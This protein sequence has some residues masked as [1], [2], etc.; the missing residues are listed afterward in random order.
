MLFPWVAVAPVALI[1][2]PMLRLREHYGHADDHP[3]RI[4]EGTN[5]LV[6]EELWTR[7]GKLWF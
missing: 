5:A 7:E 4:W 2:R 3:F 1:N 6:S